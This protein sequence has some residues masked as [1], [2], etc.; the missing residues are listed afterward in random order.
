MDI[1]SLF[2]S[3][4]IRGSIFVV[5]WRYNKYNNKT[6]ST[7]IIKTFL[8]LIRTVNNF[9]FHFKFYLQIKGCAM[10]ARCAP[11]YGNRFM[12]EFEEK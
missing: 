6:I 7:D 2:G 10:R 1:R 3:I 5:K 4:P 12:E 9:I 8:A 11:A